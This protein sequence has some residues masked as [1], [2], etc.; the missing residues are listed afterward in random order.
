MLLLS[1]YFYHSQFS[2]CFIDIFRFHTSPS[3]FYMRT[4]GFPTGIPSLQASEPR[5]DRKLSFLPLVLMLASCPLYFPL[6]PRECA[7]TDLLWP[8]MW[9][10]TLLP[11][12]GTWTLVLQNS[13]HMCLLHILLSGFSKLIYISG[14]ISSWCLS[15]HASPVHL[16][17]ANFKSAYPR[18]SFLLKIQLECHFLQEVIII[19]SSGY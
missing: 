15:V 9:L 11:V 5:L 13:L 16:R 8:C 12:G 1:R 19:F 3:C 7:N 6:Q 14:T 4:S 18:L 17:L 2:T 10:T